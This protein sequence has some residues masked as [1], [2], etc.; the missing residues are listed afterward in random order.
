MSLTTL[1]GVVSG[2]RHSTETEGHIGKGGGNVRTGQVLAF[3]IG[4]TS[5]QIKLKDVPDIRDGEQV[6][7]AGHMK[8][9]AFRALAI[10]NDTTRAVY[11]TAPMPG[12]ILGGLMV[13]VGIPLLLV[14]IGVVFIGVG[15]YTLY[16]AHNYATA[17]KMLGG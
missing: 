5:A 9:G 16:Q 8:N 2:I 14:I 7:L 3:R 1:S 12:Y 15:G 6:T 17:N 11:G 4:D 13:L 10:R